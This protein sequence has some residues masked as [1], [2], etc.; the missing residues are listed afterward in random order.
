MLKRIVVVGENSSVAET[1]TKE[2]QVRGILI[3]SAEKEHAASGSAAVI[4]GDVAAL[5][6]ADAIGTERYQMLLLLSDAIDCRED[7]PAGSAQRLCE[8]MLRFGKALELSGDDLFTLERGALLRDIGKIR[9][10][11]DILLKKSVLDYDEWVTLKSHS[12]FGAEL[13]HERQVAPD[14]IEMVEFHHE[15]WDGVGYPDGLERKE[16]PYFARILK[17]ADV[18][19]AMTSFRHYRSGH[20]SHEEAIEHLQHE[21]GKHFDPELIDVFIQENVGQTPERA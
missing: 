6:I 13:L 1:L 11:N 10:T 2:A 14:V 8:H 21:R 20:A 3:T 4:S 16:I 7:M 15:C 19:C 5:D 12:R 17:I 18:Y 9:L